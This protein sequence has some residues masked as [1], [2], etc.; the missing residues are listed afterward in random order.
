MTTVDL[1]RHNPEQNMARFYRMTLAPTLF[2][3][4][5]LIWEWGRLG[6]PGTVRETWFDSEAL[7]VEQQQK[8]LRH[9]Q[10][11]GYVDPAARIEG[12]GFRGHREIFAMRDQSSRP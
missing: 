3:E 9:K 10:R 4:W 7:A 11:R 2:G 6:S 5:A 12:P 1:E 8:R